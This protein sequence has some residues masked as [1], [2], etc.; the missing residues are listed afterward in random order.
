MKR[1]AVLI[2]ICGC[3]TAC[4]GDRS[5]MSPPTNQTNHTTPGAKTFTL[6]GRITDQQSG[7]AIG[8]ALVQIL[9]GPDVNK[10]A[11]ADANGNYTLSGLTV[12]TF[13]VQASAKGYGTS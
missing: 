9:D 13:T 12:A 4:G 3:W 11:I 1:L 10:A 6:S 5:T 2:A 8:G 7:R